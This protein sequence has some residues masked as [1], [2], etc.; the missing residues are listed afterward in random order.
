[1]RDK[2]LRRNASKM[3]KEK[4]PEEETSGAEKR[5][6]VI[7]SPPRGVLNQKGKH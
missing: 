4:Q 1:M 2:I 7:V 5:G 6:I 3:A